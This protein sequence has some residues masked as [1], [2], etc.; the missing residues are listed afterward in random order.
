[1]RLVKGRLIDISLFTMESF[2]K[3]ER[4]FGDDFTIDQIQRWYEEEKEG[5]ADL[6]SKDRTNYYYG[7]HVVNS[8]HGFSKL[9]ASS[10]ENVLG[11]GSAYGLEFLPI[12]NRISKLVIIEPSEKLR[13]EKI[14]TITP[15]YIKPQISGQIQFPDETFNLITCFSAIHHICNVTFVVGELIRVLKPGGY[16]LLREPI[17]SMGD[18]RLPRKGLTKN[19][20]GIPVKF[21]EDIFYAQNVIVEAKT[22]CFTAPGLFE[23]TIGRFLKKPYYS[24]IIGARFDKSLSFLL[25]SNSHYYSKKHLH[26]FAPSTIF[27]VI[28]KPM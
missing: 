7:Y 26:K 11:F 17:V 8:L 3:G 12:I 16:I 15:I 21:F 14:G 4:L 13:S 22:Y 20:R 1:M 6:G 27:F 5:F 24:Y 2:L 28:R 18:W 23:R 19:E 10:F 9:R 25:R